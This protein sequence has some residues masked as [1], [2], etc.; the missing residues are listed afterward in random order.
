MIFKVKAVRRNDNERSG[1]QTENLAVIRYEF[2]YLICFRTGCINILIA[3]RK[4][5]TKNQK[6]R[7]CMRAT[8]AD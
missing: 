8:M 4:N 3:R 2:M 1:L 7:K 5:K 6:L